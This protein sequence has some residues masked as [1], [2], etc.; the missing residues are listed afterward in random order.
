M[1]ELSRERF[2]TSV[3]DVKADIRF[4]GCGHRLVLVTHS[5]ANSMSTK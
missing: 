3:E 4:G 5:L 2:G 1:K